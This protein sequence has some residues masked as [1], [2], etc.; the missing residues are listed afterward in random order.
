M[1]FSVAAFI[2]ATLS[3][4]VNGTGPYTQW[5]GSTKPTEEAFYTFLNVLSDDIN[6]VVTDTGAAGTSTRKVIAPVVT[7]L[8]ERFCS[9]RST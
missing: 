4:I 6:E 2:L 1:R 5:L 3:Y 7:R 8:Q 9:G